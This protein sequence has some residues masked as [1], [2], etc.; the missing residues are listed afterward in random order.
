MEKQS[1]HPNA[2]ILNDPEAM[3]IDDEDVLQDKAETPEYD[4]IAVVKRKVVFSK[5]PMPITSAASTAALHDKEMKLAHHSAP[6][7]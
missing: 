4:I 6:L 3:A 7:K 1:P 2:S 5:R